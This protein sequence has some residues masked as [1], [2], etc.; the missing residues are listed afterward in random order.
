LFNNRFKIRHFLK[1]RAPVG[2]FVFH[3]IILQ[4]GGRGFPLVQGLEKEN[5]YK[6]ALHIK[7]YKVG[8]LLQVCSL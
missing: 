1:A 8:L 7:S 6:K 3:V 5:V 4:H 2:Q